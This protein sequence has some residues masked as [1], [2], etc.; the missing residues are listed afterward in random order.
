[1]LTISDCLTH[2]DYFNQIST[3]HVTND[4]C[5]PYVR[6]VC[7]NIRQKDNMLH[8]IDHFYLKVESDVFSS[9]FCCSLGLH[10]LPMQERFS[11]SFNWIFF[12]IRVIVYSFLP[13]NAVQ[14][15]GGN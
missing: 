9:R 6:Y 11:V 4:E 5:C 2:E 8:P 12:P 14:I 15:N 3:I 13:P 10:V 7:C 1:M